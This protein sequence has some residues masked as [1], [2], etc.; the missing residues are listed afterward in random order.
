MP[1][2]WSHCTAGANSTLLPFN[3]FQNGHVNGWNYCTNF[4][5]LAELIDYLYEQGLAGRISRL[6]INSHGS[7][8]GG[9][10]KLDR[11]LNLRSL[12]TFAAD[13]RRLARFMDRGAEHGRPK[14]IFTGC[15]AGADERG[16]I[17]LREISEIF[18]DVNVIAFEMRSNQIFSTH[19]PLAA[20]DIWI[21]GYI[22]GGV[23]PARSDPF[24]PAAKWVR[25]SIVLRYPLREQQSRR[26]QR[27]ANPAC[28]GHSDAHHQCDGG[29]HPGREWV[30]TP[31][32]SRATSIMD[33][34]R[35]EE[36]L[37]DSDYHPPSEATWYR[38]PTSILKT[39]NKGFT[40]P[41]P[42]RTKTRH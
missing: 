25:N 12:S 6:V 3:E 8:G 31:T 9:T 34:L 19:Q 35:P 42:L 24:H 33:H 40:I 38:P 7:G 1:R 36:Q 29:W 22:V 15:S 16:T 26:N 10:V 4:E 14:L 11:T 2:V 28:P 32:T 37:P 17:F 27:C 30:G 18:V 39:A 21:P 23:D 20:G 13:L 5:T 41:G